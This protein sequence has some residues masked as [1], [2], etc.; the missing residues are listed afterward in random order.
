[1]TEQ[2]SAT[3]QLLGKVYV[4]LVGINEYQYPVNTLAG[5]LNDISQIQELLAARLGDSFV[6]LPLLNEQATRQAVIEGFRQ[7]LAQAGAGD[8]ALFY[9]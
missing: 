1:M 9:I 4:L 7:H 6:P 2:Q 5:C 3:P 8:V